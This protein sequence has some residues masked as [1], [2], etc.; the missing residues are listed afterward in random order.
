MQTKCNGECKGE[1][2][3]GKGG[4]GEATAR[5]ERNQDRRSAPNSASNVRAHDRM[6]RSADMCSRPHN[7]EDVLRMQP[8]IIDSRPRS[9]LKL[10]FFSI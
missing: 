6:F 2:E 3:G 10:V 4:H 7:D 8:E 9:A 5:V 1:G